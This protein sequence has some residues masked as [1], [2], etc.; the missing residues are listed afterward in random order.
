MFIFIKFLFCKNSKNIFDTIEKA[1][2]F[3]HQAQKQPSLLYHYIF[4][5]LFY[6]WQD[7]VMNFD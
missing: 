5:L 7:L 2:F 1:F 4:T 6:H 3:E